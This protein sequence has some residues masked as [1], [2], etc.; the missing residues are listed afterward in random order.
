MSVTRQAVR[1]TSGDIKKSS[2][3]ENDSASNPIDLMS[4]FIA[5]RIDSSSSTIAIRG[6]LVGT[7]ASQ[8]RRPA[9]CRIS[10]VARLTGW[11]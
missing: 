7:A 10:V 2:A 1:R 6:L 3:D 4:P 9:S 8:L 5:S 11:I